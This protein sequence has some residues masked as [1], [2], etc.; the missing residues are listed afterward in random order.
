M[1]AQNTWGYC[2]CGEEEEE[3]EVVDS[4]VFCSYP[5]WTIPSTP[6]MV[7][8]TPEC[9]DTYGVFG[10]T[11]CEMEC[12]SDSTLREVWECVDDEETSYG[13]KWELKS[14]EVTC[15]TDEIIPLSDDTWDCDLEHNFINGVSYSQISLTDG[16]SDAGCDLNPVYG[17]ANDIDSA[18][19]YCK[20][21]CE[22]MDRCQGFFF[23]KHMNGHEICG[24]YTEDVSDA[25]R[26]WGGHQ[27]GSQI[28]MLL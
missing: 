6:A 18:V 28:C 13:G 2:N 12:S 11:Q 19:A 24:F 8:V 1:T 20:E 3:E 23:Q 5:Q 22:G 25:T 10:G 17:E 4:S 14:E 27:E 16:C 7:P 15:P 21:Q 26:S 9:V